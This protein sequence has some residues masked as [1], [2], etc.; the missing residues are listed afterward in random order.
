MIPQNKQVAHFLKTTITYM[1]TT[2]VQLLLQL[3]LPTSI[4]HQSGHYM[5]S[6]LEK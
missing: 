6:N 2:D 5:I 1:H 4:L 3:P